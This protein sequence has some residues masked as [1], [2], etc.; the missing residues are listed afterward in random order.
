ME[1]GEKEM[2]FDFFF[3]PIYFI[4]GITVFICSFIIVV[5][6]LRRR[7]RKIKLRTIILH[8]TQTFEMKNCKVK[9]DRLLINKKWKPK[10]KWNAIFVNK[11]NPSKK[12]I[13]FPNEKDEPVSFKNPE[14]SEIDDFTSGWSKDEAKKFLLKILVKGK[15]EFRPISRLEFFVLCALMVVT[16]I[17]LIMTRGV[18]F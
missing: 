10:V 7:Y 18:P 6:F 3:E 17:I 8:N 16:I 14:E 11:K 13:I 15:A 2:T 12:L 5:V 4:L 9:D 1:N